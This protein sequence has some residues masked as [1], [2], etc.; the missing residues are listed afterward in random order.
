[1]APSG[2]LRGKGRYGV[3]AGKIVWSTSERLRGEILTTRRY[4]NLRLPLR[5]W[6]RTPVQVASVSY[7]ESQTLYVPYVT[8]YVLYVWGKIREF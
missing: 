4:T 3:L 5:V 2:E 6:T 1:V 8:Y 7:T